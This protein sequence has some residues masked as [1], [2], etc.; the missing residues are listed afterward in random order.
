MITDNT[1]NTAIKILIIKTCFFSVISFFIKGFI[2]SMV[3]VELEVKT[4]EDN[5]DIEADS[6]STTTK[7]NKSSGMALLSILGTIISYTGFPVSGLVID[8]VVANSLPNP[9]KK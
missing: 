6:T 2:I 3:K 7:P 8:S 5:V 1:I 4:K 9:P